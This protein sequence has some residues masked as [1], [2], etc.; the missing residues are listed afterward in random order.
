MNGKD[1]LMGLGHVDEAY[2]QAAEEKTLRK[3]FGTVLRRYGAMAACFAV[4]IVATTVFYTRSPVGPTPPGPVV[5][6]PDISQPPEFVSEEVTV[7]M[8]QVYF[9]DAIGSQEDIWYD[10][11][12]YTITSLTGQALTDYYQ[13]DLTPLWLPDGLTPSKRNGR[14]EQVIAADGAIV[15]DMAVLD[16][17][18]GF[19]DDN[20]PELYEDTNAAKG[21]SLSVSRLGIPPQW[22]YVLPEQEHQTTD[23]DGIAVT[24]GVSIC[25]C[26]PAGTVEVINAEW[27]LGGLHFQLTAQQIERTD[28]VKTIASIITG[29]MNITIIN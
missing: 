20:L 29:T 1:L 10:P 22:D 5:A 7:D 12:V 24:L 6:L 21:L 13:R 17:Y 14:A 25:P 8:K 27:E 26:E 19:Q 23:I 2:I 11:E 15:S 3:P 4:L 9:N 28:V 16:F 18:S